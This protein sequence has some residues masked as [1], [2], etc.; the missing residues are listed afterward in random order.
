MKRILETPVRLACNGSDNVGFATLA[1]K[2]E[3]GDFVRVLIS[4]FDS[5]YN[6]FTLILRNLPWQN[7]LTKCE[8][9]LIDE[10]H[11]LTLVDRTE[12]TQS[13]SITIF[14]RMAPSSVYLISLTVVGEAKQTTT[15]TIQP[16]TATTKYES[17]FISIIAGVSIIL[18]AIA[19]I[20]VYSRKHRTQAT[21]T[22]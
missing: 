10:T 22:R 1:G 18:I 14:R 4:S 17:P 11:D 21:T 16:A 8:V 12:Y 7:R 5:S 3:N 13:G 15:A 9:H 20:V 6:Q 19:L 2:S